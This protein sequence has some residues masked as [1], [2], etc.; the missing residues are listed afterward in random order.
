MGPL[1]IHQV[2]RCNRVSAM[3]QSLR[4][5]GRMLGANMTDSWYSTDTSAAH[6]FSGACGGLPGRQVRLPE[7]SNLA[8]QNGS[9][10]VPE[11]R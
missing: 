8:S 9:V 1:P 11:R 7:R 2:E 3:L 5:L 4:V 6:G 10:L